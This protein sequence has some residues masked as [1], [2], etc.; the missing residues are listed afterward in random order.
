MHLSIRQAGLGDAEALLALLTQMHGEAAV[1]HTP[2]SPAKALAHIEAAISGG[3][4]FITEID[5]EIVGSIGGVIATDWWSDTPVFGDKWFYVVP[6]HRRSRAAH[7]LFKAFSETARNRGLIRKAGVVDGNEADR[8]DRFFE[9]FG[10]VR[11]G[12][13]YQESR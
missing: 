5:R 6:K 1:R 9:S 4:V 3:G 7:L 2:I 10:L 8:K 12:S 11:A 13:T